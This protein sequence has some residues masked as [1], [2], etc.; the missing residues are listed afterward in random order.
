MAILG[1]ILLVVL[2]IGAVIFGI[3]KYINNKS[4]SSVKAKVINK[5]AVTKESPLEDTKDRAIKK[6]KD[7]KKIK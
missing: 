4:T 7:S 5:P 3:S 1:T 6:Y 2:G